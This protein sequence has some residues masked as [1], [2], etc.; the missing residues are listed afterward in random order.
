MK[1]VLILS[2]TN[3][4]IYRQINNNE[5][6]WENY[7]FIFNNNERYD[8]LVVIDDIKESIKINA[9]C[10]GCLLF[11]GEPPS[12]RLYPH[13]Y[14]KQFD[15]IYTC[16][17]KLYKDNNTYLSIPPLPWM[18]GCNLIKGSH[19]ATSDICLTYDSLLKNKNSNRLDKICLITSNKKLT[20]G[21]R[22]RVHFALKLKN[23]MPNEIDIYGNGFTN[24]SDKFEIQTKYKYSVVIENCS[25]PNYWTEKLADTFLAGSYPIYYGAPNIL[26]YFK[27][28][29]LSTLDILD[30][31][32]SLDIIKNTIQEN[33]YEK[34]QKE[35]MDAKNLILNKYNMFTIIATAI[36]KIEQNKDKHFNNTQRIINPIKLGILDKIKHIY[37]RIIY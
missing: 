19:D 3:L 16:Q 8:Y 27:N 30:F 9:E 13:N 28:N 24:I 33:R 26:D 4:P 15:I 20:K 12:V 7:K 25:Y 10:N 17:K 14:L 23:A 34:Y 18:A 31:E 1:T 32:K 6:I 29:Q 5:Q 11:T 35:L 37:I 36:R 22:N 21:H 2:Q